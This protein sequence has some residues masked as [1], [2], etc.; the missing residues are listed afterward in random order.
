MGR[1]RFKLLAVAIIAVLG[2][3]VYVQ[4]FERP[5][6]SR[7]WSPDQRLLPVA[8]I[9]G[10]KVVIEKLRNFSYRSESD[11]TAHYETRSYDLKRLDTVWF[12]VERFG[13]TPGI[14]HTLLSFG[15]GDEYVAI[16]VEIRKEHGETYSPLKGLLRQY[17]LM[18]VIADERDVIGLRTNIRRD[19][20]Y[21]YPVKTTPQKMRQVFIEMLERANK[22]A[23]E[24]EFYNTLT[25]N[26]TSNIVKHVNTIS[27]RIPFSY[28]V[29]LPAYADQLAHELDLIPTDQPFEAIQ[30]AHRIDP[31]AQ[32]FGIRPDFSRAV[33][34]KGPAPS[35]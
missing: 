15:F 26:C 9:T 19:P 29:L 4:V 14:A 18:Y 8:T 34:R 28:K 32:K 20:V 21:M 35:L 3:F 24:P 6:L 23:I 11:H 22:L 33:R 2:P 16:S 30:A 5:S 13:D 1:T 17:E 12:I 7:N 31:I 27:P 25:N 10:D